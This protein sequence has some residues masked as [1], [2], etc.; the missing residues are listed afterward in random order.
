MS[1]HPI[2][3]ILLDLEKQRIEEQINQQYLEQNRL[4]KEAAGGLE[5]MR[6]R[7]RE[8]LQKQEKGKGGII[9]SGDEEGKLRPTPT[10][11]PPA[12]PKPPKP[13]PIYQ[14]A[15][16]WSDYDKLQTAEAVKARKEGRKPNYALIKRP[17]FVAP[18][19]INVKIDYANSIPNV[20]RNPDYDEFYGGRTKI[21]TPEEF[22]KNKNMVWEGKYK[23]YED[24][25]RNFNLKSKPF[26]RNIEYDKVLATYKDKTIQTSKDETINPL[27]QMP[28]TKELID[29]IHK[30]L[31]PTV[32]TEMLNKIHSQLNKKTKVSF[33]KFP[34]GQKDKKLSSI[35]GDYSV[36]FLP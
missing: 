19:P 33:N 29:N 32:D 9:T 30:K 23:N 35:P 14:I 27:G 13:L 6:Q 34:V 31:N 36:E 8:R 18:K 5:E 12:K 20:I 21:D 17:G 3:Q 22:E 2:S 25:K 4:R 16:N 15:K 10:T 26:I 1:S 28:I 11:G 24:Y 7:T